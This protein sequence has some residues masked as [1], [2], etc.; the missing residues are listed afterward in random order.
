MLTVL[1]IVS[2]L[3][4]LQQRQNVT[5]D[6]MKFYLGIITG[7]IVYAIIGSLGLYLLKICWADY[8]IASRDKS[9]TIQMLLSRLLVAML[10]SIITGISSCKIANDKGKSSWFVAVIVFCIA[11]YIHFL[12]VWADYPI[13]YHFAYLL[14]IIPTIGLSHSILDCRNRLN[15]SS[16]L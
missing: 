9:Y 7:L 15:S 3:V 1:F 12:R 8:N 14:P 6:T 2:V 11:A 13:W 10:A 16:D 5:E 4:I